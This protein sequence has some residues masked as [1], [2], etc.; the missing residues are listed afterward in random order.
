MVLN[1]GNICAGQE[2]S[3]DS[4]QPDAIQRYYDA[5][6][7]SPFRVNRSLITQGCQDFFFYNTIIIIII[8]CN[9]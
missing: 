6:V 7:D 2:L 1:S 5:S 4:S 9:G 8:A 3:H